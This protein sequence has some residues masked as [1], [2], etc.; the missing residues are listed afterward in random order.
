MTRQQVK[1]VEAYMI[2]LKDQGLIEP[3]EERR[4]WVFHVAVSGR[5]SELKDGTALGDEP[6][7]EAFDNDVIQL[8]TI[9][10]TKNELP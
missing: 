4:Q 8:G 2:P 6:R 10:P 5:Y 1:W 7:D 9:L 3:E